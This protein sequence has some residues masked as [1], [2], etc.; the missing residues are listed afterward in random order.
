MMRRVASGRPW[1]KGSTQQWTILEDNLL[2][3]LVEE[4]GQGMTRRRRSASPH[5][6]IRLYRC[7]STSTRAHVPHPP[8]WLECV[9]AHRYNMSKPRLAR[10]TAFINNSQV[11]QPRERGARPCAE[12]PQVVVHREQDERAA[13][14]AVPRPVAEP[15][16]ARHPARRVD[17]GG[18]A[19]PGT[20]V[21]ENKHSTDFVNLLLLLL[22]TSVKAFTLKVNHACTSDLGWSGCCE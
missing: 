5:C 17:G 8:P 19:H 16:Q 14:Q 18:G 15:P 1:L 4:H 11:E 21:I 12:A 6:L 9:R 20:G 13:G 3:K 10:K 7:T 22:S 2:R